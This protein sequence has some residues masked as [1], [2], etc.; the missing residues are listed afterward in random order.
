VVEGTEL[1]GFDLVGVKEIVGPLDGACD[2]VGCMLAVGTELGSAEGNELGIVEGTEL[3]GLDDVGAILN[4]GAFDGGLD[5]VGAAL[6]VGAKL[7]VSEGIELGT[8][9]GA[10]DDVGT[11]DGAI[12][13][14]GS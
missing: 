6:P 12:E 14:V 4:V 9:L 10:T 7:G 3:G 8:M 5:S 2:I 13:L 11:P 1:G